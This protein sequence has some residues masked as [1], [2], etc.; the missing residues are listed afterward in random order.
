MFF[1]FFVAFT[2]CPVVKSS[3]N[4]WGR[5]NT[6]R[7]S[8]KLANFYIIPCLG[9]HFYSK[10][11]IRNLYVEWNRATCCKTFLVLHKQAFVLLK[12]A[13]PS[14]LLIMFYFEIPYSK[15]DLFLS[16][17]TYTVSLWIYSYTA[18]QTSGML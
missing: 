10:F 1:L 18:L 8:F 16:C 11:Y 2:F 17:K 5:K 9:F 15:L 3:W 4:F 14:W 12:F 7:S 6:Q 13:T